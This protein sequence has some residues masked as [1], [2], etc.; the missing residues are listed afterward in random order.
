MLL[1]L[2][3][4][5]DSLS[6][7]H[8]NPHTFLIYNDYILCELDNYSNQCSVMI[9]TYYY[10]TYIK[11]DTLT[12]PPLKM[13]YLLINTIYMVSAL[14]LIL[15]HLNYPAHIANNCLNLL[16]ILNTY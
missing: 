13:Y 2:P 14:L 12:N 10:I 5:C 3:L 8:L 9:L 11:F 6:L 1:F 7:L 15:L 16:V 4:L